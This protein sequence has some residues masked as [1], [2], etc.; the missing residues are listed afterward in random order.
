MPIV[1]FDQKEVSPNGT[2]NWQ[3]SSSAASEATFRTV[4]TAR[5]CIG[6]SPTSLLSTAGVTP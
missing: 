2:R 1:W 6:A 5:M 4:M 3:I